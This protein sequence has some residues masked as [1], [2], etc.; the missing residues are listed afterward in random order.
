VATQ[1]NV[2]TIG[3]S[4]ILP[5]TIA[6]EQNKLR[7]QTAQVFEAL[8]NS[9]IQESWLGGIRSARQYN[10]SNDHRKLDAFVLADRLAFETYRATQSFSAA[11]TYGLRSQIRR[12]AISVPTNIVEGCSRDSNR[13]YRHFLSIAF[14]ST[15]EVIYLLDLSVRLELLDNTTTRPLIDLGG[16][17]AAALAALKKSIST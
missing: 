5:S 3:V 14:G 9:R 16:R 13:E 17:I 11:E 12:A 1:I 8:V 6:C 10:M 7:C 4:Q 15:R 2:F